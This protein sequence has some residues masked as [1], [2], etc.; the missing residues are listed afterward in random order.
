MSLRAW[1]VKPG[2]LRPLSRAG[3]LLLA[4][5][6]AMRAEPWRAPGLDRG[7][8]AGLAHLLA[9]ASRPPAPP[10]AAARALARRI[11]DAGATACNRLDGTDGE[12]LGRC[13]NHAS[14]VLEVALEATSL[15]DRALVRAL[16]DIAK[17]ANS[18]P[19][20]L[21]HAG[22]VRAPRGASAIDAACTYV[23]DATRADV[24]ALARATDRV[25]A[26]RDRAAALRRVAP[27]WPGRAPA[28]TRRR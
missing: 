9:A 1:A 2:E 3:L 17:L 16:V 15:Q 20:V 10:T 13:H 27:L 21:A 28:W 23:W 18:I 12:A 11:Q 5:R 14:N 26:A 22:L 4:A 25:I 24:A 6:C 19:A 7:W 8:R